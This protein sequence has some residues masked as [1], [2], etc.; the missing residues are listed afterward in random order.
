MDT[1][2]LR[3]SL[4]DIFYYNKVDLYL[5]GHVHNYE[6]NTPIYKNRTMIGTFDDFHHYVNPGATVYITSGNAGNE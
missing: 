2:K 3:K 5:Q 6:R 1:K 4:E